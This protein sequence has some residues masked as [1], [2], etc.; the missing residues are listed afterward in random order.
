MEKTIFD[1]IK[2][3]ETGDWKEV[4]ARKFSAKELEAI[5]NCTVVKGDYSMAVRVDLNIGGSQK[6]AFLTLDK[7]E[8][9]SVGESLDKTSL[10]LVHLRYEGGANMKVKE[11]IVVR[12]DKPQVQ[13]SFDNPFGL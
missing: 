12:I 2:L 8:V 9:C 11:T 1:V 6:A 13:A 5:V 4:G 7:K 10:K 3:Y